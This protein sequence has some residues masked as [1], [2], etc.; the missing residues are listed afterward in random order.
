MV[1]VVI[2]G[3]TETFVAVFPDLYPYFRFEVL[4]LDLGLGHHQNPLTGTLCLI[5]R[6]TEQWRVTD[7]LA[8]FLT[9]RLPRTL[10]AGATDDPAAVADQEQHQA[11]PFSDY[12]PYQMS[13]VL[14][15]DSAWDLSGVDRG[16][17]EAR[18][19][20]DRE[21]RIRGGVVGVV[22]E[23]DVLVAEG[24]SEWDRLFE[25]RMRGRWA[26]VQAP[27][28]ESDPASA[29]LQATSADP[30]LHGYRWNSVGRTL[31][32]IVGVIFPE[33]VGWRE[34]GDGWVFLVSLA[35]PRR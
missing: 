10:Q 11:E 22:D 1:E 2:N 13:T 12:Y 26:R 34:I 32:D 30:W 18:V 9:E 15:V 28:V 7:T 33:E 27:I 23:K 20:V 19:D 17:F 4:G 35:R 29:R 6:A 31:V 24:P 3:R 25:T 16:S 14:M 21:G 5:G 8:A